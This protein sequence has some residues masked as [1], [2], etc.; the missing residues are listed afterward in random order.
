MYNCFV[1]STYQLYLFTFPQS[2]QWFQFVHCFTKLV[3]FFK[4]T[5]AILMGVRRYLTVILI[6]I[7]L[8]ISDAEHLF[9]ATHIPSLEKCLFQVLC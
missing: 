4:K 9:V 5:V 7:S 2:A 6:C 8:M 3:F 1:E